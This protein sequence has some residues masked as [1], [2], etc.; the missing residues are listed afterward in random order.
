MLSAQCDELRRLASTL[1]TRY[2]Y[3]DDTATA[4][5]EAADTI[6][7]LRDRAQDLQAENAELRKELAKARDP[8]RIGGTADPESFVYA[9]EQLREFRWQH[10]TN[11]EEAIPYINNVAD[12]H[13][14]E[15][16]KLRELCE[17]MMA[18]V[19]DDDACERCGHDAECIE[20][21]DGEI[22]LPYDGRCLMLDLFA[23]R[24]RELWVFGGGV[25][26]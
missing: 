6:L 18:F 13:E 23:D 26:E 5:R 22:V 21:A 3:A 4:L 20:A 11:D 2:R 16:A 7:S 17:D 1:D 14:R 15:N 24:M 9:I 10:A 19:E 12:A 25:D 8:Q